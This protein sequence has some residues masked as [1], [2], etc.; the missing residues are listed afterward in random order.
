MT[1][2]DL[3]RR[4]PSAITE[5]QAVNDVLECATRLD[6]A[7][8][9]DTAVDRF[10]RL[11]TASS[12]TILLLQPDGETLEVAAIRYERELHAADWEAK[13]RARR[14]RLGEGLV[15]FAAERRTPMLIVDVEADPR[16]R[17]LAGSPR[18]P[19]AGIIVPLEVEGQLL[20]V[21]QAVKRGRGSFDEDHFRAAQTLARVSALTVLTVRARRDLSE[22]AREL[23]LLH[24]TSL[25]LSHALSLSEALDVLVV[26]AARL[27]SAEA[28]LVLRLEE[29]HLVP[30]AA[31][32]NVDR[33]K[34]AGRVSQGRMTSELLTAKQTV[35]VADLGADGRLRWARELGM[36]SAVGV[37]LRSEGVVLGALMLAHSSLGF[38]EEADARRLGVLAAQAAAALARARSF[39][40][41]QR[42]A[43]TD[44]LTGLH[45]ARYFSARLR[46]EV[47]RA[48]RYGHALSLVLFDSDSLKVV[49]DCFG[50]DEGNR[51]LAGL[52]AI[53]RRQVRTTDL[54][55][56]F[57]G[58][59]FV[60]LQPE[61]ELAA[62][63]LTG[64]RIR[65]AAA[66]PFVTLD[67]RSVATTVSVG[68]AALPLSAR[69]GDGLFRA[70]DEAL[71]TAKRLGK[72]RVVA[73]RPL[74][75]AAAAGS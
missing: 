27:V 40:E 12:T 52:G 2:A 22:Q 8:A 69:D 45:N 3:D 15:G 73:A 54:L 50:H 46:E 57:G 74:S 53:V 21:I 64:E 37:P 24:E 47:A 18:W 13:Q 58:D 23:Q 6:L 11:T 30:L 75:E 10:H 72:D 44:D 35:L 14:M 26:G 16:A 31:T 33:A 41:A 71:Y 1:G 56:R 60:V 9:L 25:K 55:A 65:A 17:P 38:F 4:P 39:A 51:L 70:A 59:E 7:A 28:G 66:V 48:A 36:Q 29:G 67:G 19:R 63:L 49:N 61:T 68:V 20:G 32:P 34:L 43:V 62:A 42:V 5:L